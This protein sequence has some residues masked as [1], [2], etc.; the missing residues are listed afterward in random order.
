M[1]MRPAEETCVDAEAL[2]LDAL[3]DAERAA[4][5]AHLDACDDCRARYAAAREVAALLARSV[6]QA[7]PPPGLGTRVLAQALAAPAPAGRSAPARIAWSWLAAAAVLV[8]VLGWNVTLQAQ[9]RA[10]AEQTEALATRLTTQEAALRLLAP[11]SGVARPLVGSDVAPRAQGALYLDPQGTTGLLVVRDLPAPPP[12]KVY[13]LWL[14]HDGQ[15]AS[16]GLFTV[17]ERGVAV[18][19][20]QAPQPLRTYQA[21]GVTAEPPGGSPGPT[22]PRVIGGQ[23]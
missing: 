6:P 18:L 21:V 13:Q 20:V 2:A 3:D 8:A 1:N 19:V 23:L 14:I 10:Q 7:V 5:L 16:G 15:R 11:G 9:L 4:A 22:G 17:D 12:G